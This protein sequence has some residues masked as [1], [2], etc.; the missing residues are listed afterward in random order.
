MSKQLFKIYA[1]YCYVIAGIVMLYFVGFFENLIVPRQIS[2]GLTETPQLHIESMLIDL[3][4]LLIFGLQHSLM[5]RKWFKNWWKT[6]IPQQIERS[7]YVLI[8]SLALALIIWQ[9]RPFGMVIWDVRTDALGILL[10]G[11]SFTGLLITTISVFSISVTHFA[12]WQQLNTQTDLQPTFVTP[13]FYKIVRHPIYFGFLL[14]F[15]STPLMTLS[16]LF[17]ALVMTTYILIGIHFE[18]QDLVDYYGVTYLEYRQRVAML[19]PF[20]KI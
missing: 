13:L 14:S 20:V 5:A 3:V 12:G 18:E 7:T 16:H 6:I 4:L 8:S 1:L 2:K 19:I 10:Y 17:F 9:W 11:V 15:W